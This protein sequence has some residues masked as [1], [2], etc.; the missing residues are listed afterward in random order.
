M[1]G[2]FQVT[3]EALWKLEVYTLVGVYESAMISHGT[4]LFFQLPMFLDT[5]PH[6]FVT[7]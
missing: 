4:S 1:T 5:K 6:Y 3:S 2:A 7:Y